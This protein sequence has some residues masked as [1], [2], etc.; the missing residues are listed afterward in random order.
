MLRVVLGIW[1]V[2]GIVYALFTI[3]FPLG[4]L[5]ALWLWWIWHLSAG[6]YVDLRPKVREGRCCVTCCK[7]IPAARACLFCESGQPLD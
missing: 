5:A 1:L 4:A 3:S 2:I 7:P 6:Y